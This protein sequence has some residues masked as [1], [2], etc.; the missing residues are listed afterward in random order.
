MQI[1]GD[2]N[3]RQDQE[4]VAVARVAVLAQHA[5]HLGGVLVAGYDAVVGA[6]LQEVEEAVGRMGVVAGEGEEGELAV[7]G[8]A[9]C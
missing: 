3:E 7:S 9:G 2:T 8:R 6:F 5:E 4:H 1:V